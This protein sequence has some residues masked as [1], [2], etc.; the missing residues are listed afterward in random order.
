V[1]AKRIQV[2][3]RQ[4]YQV[5]VGAGVLS[6]L[7]RALPGGPAAVVTDANVER[8]QAARLGGCAGLPR[9]ALPPGEDSKTFAA[10]ERVLDFLLASGLDR[11]ATLIAFGGGVVGD[12]GGLAAALFMRG[13][14][15]VQCPTTLLAQV[16]SALGGKTAVN[17]RAGKNLA[18]VFHQPRLVLAD[19]ETLA[20]LPDEELRSGLGEVVKYALLGEGELLGLLEHESRLLLARDAALLSE[21]VAHCVRHKAALVARDEHERHERKL[22][23]LG[24][25]FAHALERAAGFGRIPHGLAVGVGLVLALRASERAGLLEDRELPL[26]IA[27]LLGLLGLPADLAALRARHGVRLAPGEL[28]AAMRHD[29][30]GRAERPA[31]VLVR[32]LGKLALDQELDARALGEL[33]A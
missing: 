24:H 33:L 28:R 12:L 2:A 25:T 20:T 13:I 19:T 15:C 16:D 8:L 26:R 22:L 9:L 5:V 4:P 18:G 1:S 30:K 10:L 27:R 6:E 7:E 23:N 3:T 21:V 11:R 31:F 14:D 32:R 17:L 29:K